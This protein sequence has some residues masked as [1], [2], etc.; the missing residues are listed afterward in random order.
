MEI[1]VPWSTIAEKEER[2]VRPM[3]AATERPHLTTIIMNNLWKVSPHKLRKIGMI[4]MFG[5]L[6]SGKLI[7]RCANDRGDLMKLL[8]ERHENPNLVS[9][10][11]KLSMME[12]R[13]PL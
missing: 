6:K 9:L 12:P 3:S 2:P 1:K 7:L 5:L 11:W 10:T 13:N 4:T 8:G